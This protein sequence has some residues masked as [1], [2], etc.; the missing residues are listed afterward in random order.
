MIATFEKVSCT[1]TVSKVKRK[2]TQPTVSAWKVQLQI[3][4]VPIQNYNNPVSYTQNQLFY[5]DE[6]EEIVRCPY[7]EK[8][9]IY[10]TQEC[11]CDRINNIIFAMR[12]YLE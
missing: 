8:F 6:E 5:Q 2:S 10:P 11:E 9:G 3:E 7:C 1:E 12:Y 4:K